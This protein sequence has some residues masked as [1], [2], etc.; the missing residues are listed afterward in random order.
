MDLVTVNENALANFGAA[1][2][3][4]SG[5]QKPLLRFVKGD[6]YL[7]QD[8]DE[9]PLGAKFALNMPAV[10]WGWIFWHDEKPEERRMVTVASGQPIAARSNLGHEDKE[11]WRRDNEGNPQDPWQKTIE[12]PARELASEKRE[13]VIA[14]SSKGWEGCCKAL[15]K[16]F[17]EGMRAN[18]G[19][20][21]VVELAVGKYDHKKYGIT[22]VP[23]L[24][25][26]AWQTAEELE[27]A[28]AAP[29][30]KKASTKF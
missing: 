9:I 5:D 27:A 4:L 16:A 28:V 1:A 30:P 21:P 15:F 3:A 25:I 24:N 13:V 22:K 6:W 18:P 23:V 10:E 26:V 8:K 20:V 29:A 12:I 11:L 2:S 14:G 17:G 19:R 7:G